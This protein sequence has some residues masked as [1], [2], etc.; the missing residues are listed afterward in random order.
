[1][2]DK[3]ADIATLTKATE[4]LLVILARNLNRTP[5]E[6]AFLLAENMSLLTKLVMLGKQKD[7]SCV[8]RIFEEFYQ[9][10]DRI[11]SLALT[12]ETRETLTLFLDVVRIGFISK[13]EQVTKWT[14]N[15]TGKIVLLLAQKETASEVY[16]ILIK[17]NKFVPVGV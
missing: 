8:V 5:F 16:Q 7:Y 3:K 4:I 6:M 2:L 9:N 13:D 17:D 15:T 10:A 11:L 1:M 12:D 14:V